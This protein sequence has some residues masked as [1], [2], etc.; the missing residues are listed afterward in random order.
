MTAHECRE[1]G[2]V[3]EW[4]VGDGRVVCDNCQAV[5]GEVEWF[6]NVGVIE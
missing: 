5:N 3:D 4:R 6:P 2:H 1:C